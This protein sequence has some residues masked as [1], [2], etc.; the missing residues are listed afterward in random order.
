MARRAVFAFLDPKLDPCERLYFAWYALYF[1]EGWQL[2]CSEEE[3]LTKSFLSSNQFA[4]IRLNAESLLLL[5][6]WYLSCDEF[7]SLP[8]AHHAC[9]S[10]QAEEFFRG[11]R[12]MFHDPNF[13]IS[14]CLWRTSYVQAEAMIQR[15][16]ADEFVFPRHHKHSHM[17]RVRHPAIT[18]PSI[19]ELDIS[20]TLTRA[21]DDAVRD[22]Q[23][24]VVRLTAP[25]PAP[26]PEPMLSDEPSDA[27]ID[28]V[29]ECELVAADGTGLSTTS[30][31]EE[32][33][34]LVSI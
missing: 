23:A 22:L 27:C 20:N 25:S 30:S 26:R 16:R 33:H 21:R 17:D 29:E 14:G 32:E 8:F 34:V 4:C 18:L 19:R 1:A 24:L 13:T 7:R 6:L 15:R 3:D 10:Q 11:L 31:D 28:D 2:D 5:L 12:A 9:A